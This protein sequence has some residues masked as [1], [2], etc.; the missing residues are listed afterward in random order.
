MGVRARAATACAGG[1]LHNNNNSTF[2]S[3]LLERG[4]DSEFA[5]RLDT[6]GGGGAVVA[7]ASYDFALAKLEL[8]LLFLFSLRL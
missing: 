6:K 4:R 5:E 7:A 3:A 1:V 8:L 2:M